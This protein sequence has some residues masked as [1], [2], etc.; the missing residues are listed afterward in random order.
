M[1]KGAPADDRYV[2]A[3]AAAGGRIESAPGREGLVLDA[4][5]AEPDGLIEEEV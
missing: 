1:R 2:Q 5:W 3:L 4:L